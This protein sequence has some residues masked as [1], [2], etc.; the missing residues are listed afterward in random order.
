MLPQTSILTDTG[1]LNW[2]RS[3]FN[4]IKYLTPV[5]LTE[6]LQQFDMGIFAA[7]GRVLWEIM[8]RDEVIAAVAG[9]RRQKAEGFSYTIAKKPDAPQAIFDKH[10][11]VLKY[12][13]D[14]LRVTD[15]LDHDEQ[16]GVQGFFGKMNNA[17]GMRWQ[18]FEMLAKPDAAS[19]GLTFEMVA[20][21]L[22]MFE[23]R[24]GRMRFLPFPGAYDG[25]EMEPMRWLVC[26]GLGLMKPSAIAYMNMRIPKQNWLFYTEAYATPGIIAKTNHAKG[27][28]GYSALETVLSKAL[29]P[30]FRAI[31][32]K[33]TGG[34]NGN[35][36]EIE[37]LD[38]GSSGQ[39]PFKDILD[40]HE[41]K[42]LTLWEGGDLQ[43]KSS[44]TSGSVGTNAQLPN[45]DAI[46]DHD[47]LKIQE[48]L[49]FKIDPMVIAYHFGESVESAAYIKVFPKRQPD[50]DTELKKLTFARGAGIPIGIDS[51]R[52]T[53][54]L[55]TPDDNEELIEP[56]APPKPAF[57][58]NTAHNATRTAMESLQRKTIERLA[59]DYADK[60]KPLADRLLGIIEL[61]EKAGDAAAKVAIQNL[62]KE[63]PQILSEMNKA[64]GGATI[65]LDSA[66]T[67]AFLNG[68]AQETVRA[69]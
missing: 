68:V 69:A 44:E 26:R 9:K 24:L 16:A 42:V 18:N 10:A 41:K 12:C 17:Q 23:N 58:Q 14:N 28:D 64:S 53:L 40:W 54:G 43:S 31:L 52:E 61:Y 27:T 8:E 1:I 51:T 21:P 19:G 50:I 57:G 66:M 32:T 67:A 3:Y 4:P 63:S 62:I 36:D 60:N 39:L 49:N 30:D 55:H 47:A 6:V 13:Y 34:T 2:K 29:G 7:A 65:T 20:C 38:F 11:A 22:W 33:G 45:A 5:Y 56:P 35:G 25:D 46:E 48:P 15:A 59:N 37:K